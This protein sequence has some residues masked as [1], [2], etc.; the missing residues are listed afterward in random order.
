VVHVHLFPGAGPFVTLI[1][2]G[3]TYSI[4]LQIIHRFEKSIPTFYF[5]LCMVKVYMCYSQPR[6]RNYIEETKIL[7]KFLRKLVC[8]LLSCLVLSL[9]QHKCFL[10]PI[11][12]AACCIN[13]WLNLSNVTNNKMCVQFYKSIGSNTNMIP[14]S[15]FLKKILTDF[16]SAD[17]TGSWQTK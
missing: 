8:N 7:R 5:P 6:K 2:S 10:P 9:Y 13:H 15:L 3:S 1:F 16:Q 17:S 4:T 11:F 12:P 14:L